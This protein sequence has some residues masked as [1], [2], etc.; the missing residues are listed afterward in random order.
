MRPTLNTRKPIHQ[1][2][3]DELVVFPVW[4]FAI[5]EEGVEGRDETWARP[6]DVG[7]IPKGLWS[8]SVAADFR[9]SSGVTI[10]GFV[11]VTTADGVR[12]GDGVLLP[13]DPRSCLVIPSDHGR[14]AIVN[15]DR[16]RY[17]R[18]WGSP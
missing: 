6:V 17:E 4:E 8:L 1:L 14:R 9:T 16:R 2:S 7:T 18:T 12:L 13:Q 5:E 11:G 3:T 15:R 10:P